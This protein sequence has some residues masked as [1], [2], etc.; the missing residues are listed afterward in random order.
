MS[1]GHGDLPAPLR[2]LWTEWV[3]KPNS[4]PTVPSIGGGHSSGTGVAT[5][6]E[7]PTRGSR[8]QA[9]RRTAG[10]R[11]PSNAAGHRFPPIWPCTGW[12]LP[13]RR[14]A[15]TPVRS[16]RTFSPLL[17]ARRAVCFLLRFPSGRPAFLLGSTLPCGVRTFLR[18]WTSLAGSRRQPN[19]GDHPTH[20]I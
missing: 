17:A 4:V 8:T 16:C 2:W 11:L 3:C 7:R 1:P 18:V 10:C 9:A 19:R 6:L 14:V 5:G 12:G 15:T 13:G 20:S